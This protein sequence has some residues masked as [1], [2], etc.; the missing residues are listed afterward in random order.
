MRK[1]I[2]VRVH[3]ANFLSMPTSSD[4]QI[5]T[6]LAL[7]TLCAPARVIDVGIGNGRYGVLL[8]DALDVFH[9]P[10][11]WKVRID[12]LEGFPAYVTAVHR[13]VYDNIAYGDAAQLVTALP[14]DAY[15]LALLIDV[16]ERMSPDQG[17]SVLTHLRRTATSVVV[18]TPGV[19]FAQGSVHGNRFEEHR[20][21]WPRRAFH[22]ALIIPNE[23]QTIA[24]YSRSPTVLARVRSWRTRQLLKSV[25]PPALH[26]LLVRLFW[27]VRR[28]RA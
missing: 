13:Y 16:I 14:N 26:W 9:Q 15:D 8:R 22:G 12:G 3:V 19:W 4:R 5:A 7:A 24:F 6:V 23:A 27:A 20:T 25:V 2:G 1:S 11:Q 18:C 10:E 28:M 21:F 17:R